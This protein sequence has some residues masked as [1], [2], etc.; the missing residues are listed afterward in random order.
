MPAFSGGKSKTKELKKKR[1]QIENIL[2]YYE[3]YRDFVN[4]SKK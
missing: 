3:K 2:V 4:F 1:W